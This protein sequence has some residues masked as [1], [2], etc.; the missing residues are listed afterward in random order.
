MTIFNLLPRY[1]NNNRLRRQEESETQGSS[2][3]NT[4]SAESATEP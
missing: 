2:D 1:M 3:G 4:G